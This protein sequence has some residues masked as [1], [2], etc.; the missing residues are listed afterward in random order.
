L[1]NKGDIEYHVRP[2]TRSLTSKLARWFKYDYPQLSLMQWKVDDTS[3]LQKCFE[4]CYGASIDSGVLLPPNT[5]LKEWTR[6]ELALGK[7]CCQAAEVSFPLTQTVVRNLQRLT[8]EIGS[9]RKT[10]Y[11]TGIF[12]LPNHMSHMNPAQLRLRLAQA[13]LPYLHTY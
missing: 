12:S 5:P 1:F 3:S 11:T 6:I 7:R 13:C 4:G 2:L 8:S 10:C 9:R